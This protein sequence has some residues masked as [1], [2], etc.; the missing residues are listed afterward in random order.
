M[1]NDNLV[2]DRLQED[3]E[4]C[5]ALAT[6]KF[7]YKMAAFYLIKGMKIQDSLHAAM[8]SNKRKQEQ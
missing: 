1:A 7:T 3:Q 6:D 2:I 4:F 8:D 5:K